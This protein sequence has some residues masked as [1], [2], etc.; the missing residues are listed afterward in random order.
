M[1]KILDGVPVR[2]DVLQKVT[3]GL[4]THKALVSVLVKK[5]QPAGELLEGGALR[6][7]N[8]ARYALPMWCDAKRP[9]STSGGTQYRAEDRRGYRTHPSRRDE[10]RQI[11]REDGGGTAEHEGSNADARA[12][13]GH[14][15]KEIS[16]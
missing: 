11:F 8:A 2:E 15:R 7:E 13:L 4:S 16:E 5:R 3:D 10:A 1:Q 14:A 9:L 6:S 12:L